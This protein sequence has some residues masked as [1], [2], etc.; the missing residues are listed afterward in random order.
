MP[1]PAPVPGTLVPIPRTVNA[2]L[3]RYRSSPTTRD[4][5]LVA[6]N[7][8]ARLGLEPIRLSPP[9]TS[10]CSRKC[11]CRRSCYRFRRRHHLRS[12]SVIDKGAG[13]VQ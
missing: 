8:T 4:T 5:M 11:C 3:C 6:C 10:P 7:H 12:K 13:R 1:I 2:P 9:A